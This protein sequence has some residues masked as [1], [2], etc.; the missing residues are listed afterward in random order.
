MDDLSTFVTVAHRG[1]ITAAAQQ[2][3]ISPATT[4]HRIAKLE[5]ALRLTLFHRNSR[6]FQLTD[7]G[8]RYLDRIEPVL[9]DLAAARD[10]AGGTRTALRGHL[11]VTLS[12]WIL[13]RYILPALAPF[14]RAHPELS[15]EFLAVDRF[16]SLVEEGQDCAVR[17]GQLK[18]SGLLARRIADNERVLCAAPSY[19]ADAGAPT[20]ID[21]LDAHSW[22]CLPW[23]MRLPLRTPLGGERP[24]T[25]TRNILVSN[26]DM[27]TDAAVNGLGIA[28]KSRLA[29]Q[30]ELRD[31]RLVEVLP[32]ALAA[33]DAPIWFVSAPESRAG[34]KNR[35]F[36]GFVASRFQ[37]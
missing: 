29:V 2:L 13:S 33:A 16:V 23:Q 31:G 26:S 32:G 1:G 14:K 35:A 7:E 34:L 21:T 9:D 10:D 20:D 17:V 18:D 15:L 8:Q 12:P 19:L 24:F 28:I 36:G 22:V 27:L 37:T 11:R 30:D 6:S 4:S 5:R 3:G 25:A